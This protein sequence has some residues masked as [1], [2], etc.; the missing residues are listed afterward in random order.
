MRAG[1]EFTPSLPALIL[2]RADG[3]F[4]HGVLGIVRSLGRLG[5]RVHLVH[6]DRSTPAAV[7][8][9]CR[10]GVVHC[11]LGASDEVVLERLEEFGRR[12]GP[13]VLIPTDDESVLLVE[14]HADELRSSFLF[15]EQP[16]GLAET[17]SNKVEMARLCAEHGVPT[18]WVHAVRDRDDLVSMSGE[19][20]YPIALKSI[21]GGRTFRRTGERM[22]IV[23]DAAARVRAYAELEHPELPSLLLQEDIPGGPESVWM[24]NGYFDAESECRGAVTGREL[25]QLPP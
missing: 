20:A 3:N 25:R 13:A 12:T 21:D 6:H 18:P 11:P 10:G 19:V 24:L 23:D 22:R 1:V 8:R 17:L 15:P 9:Y 7:S 5:V 2:Q 4:Q 16:D 14:E